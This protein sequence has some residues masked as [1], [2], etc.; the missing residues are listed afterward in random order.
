MAKFIAV[1][2]ACFALTAAGLVRRDAPAS[3]AL[4]DLQKHAAEFQKTFTEQLNA[5]VNSKSTKEVTKA[6]Q[7]GSESVL[8][9]VS[10]LSSSLQGAVGDA[11]GKAKEALEAARTNLEKTVEDLRKAHPEVEQ[12]ATALRDKLKTAV[13]NT[14]KQTQELAKTVASNVEDTNKKLEPKIKAAYDDFVKHAQEVQKKLHEAAN[15]Q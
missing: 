3:N 6:L 9:Q 12:Q 4:D 13:D 2:F 5:L 14:L 15:K 1:L 8:K 10:T 11:N 7:E